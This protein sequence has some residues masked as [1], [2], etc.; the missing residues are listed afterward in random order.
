MAGYKNHKMYIMYWAPERL[1]SGVANVT[2]FRSFATASDI[3]KVIIIHQISGSAGLGLQS[4]ARCD[5]IGNSIALD[6]GG[7]CLFNIP[8][9]YCEVPN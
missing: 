3:T 6:V 7:S 5:S 1:N 2:A 4:L 9:R 8:S